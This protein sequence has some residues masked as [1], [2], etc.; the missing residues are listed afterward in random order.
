MDR[1]VEQEIHALEER[2]NQAMLKPDIDTLGQLLGESLVYTYWS[3]GSDGKA[4]YLESMKTGRFVY[5]KIER[6]EER[7]RYTATLL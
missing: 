5:R 3:G 4:A 2:R 7:P 1:T 6:P